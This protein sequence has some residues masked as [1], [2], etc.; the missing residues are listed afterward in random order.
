MVKANQTKE[1]K[2]SSGGAKEGKSQAHQGPEKMVKVQTEVQ[3]VGE[4]LEREIFSSLTERIKVGEW[5][6]RQEQGKEP[7][8]E[9]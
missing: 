7:E 8:Q 6:K 1:R 4:K 5:T 2:K 9:Q 3:E